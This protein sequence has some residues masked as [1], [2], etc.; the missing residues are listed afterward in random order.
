MLKK[1][2]KKLLLK[3][4]M[5][6]LVATFVIWG[7]GSAVT[8]KKGSAGSIFGRKIS[9]QEYNR[10]YHAILTRAQLIYGDNLSKFEKFLNLGQQ[11][12]DRLI[13][14]HEAR[15]KFRRPSDKEA[16]ERIANMQVFQRNGVFN[17]KLYTYII[18]DIFHSTPHDFEESVKDDLILE[19]LTDSITG[20]VEALDDEVLKGY[21]E[22]NELTDA[23][24]FLI[25]TD[26]YKKDISVDD[27]EIRF[28]YEGN[29]EDYKSPISANVNYIKIGF[30]AEEKEDARFTAEELLRYTRQHDSLKAT[31]GEYQVELKE[32]GP[33]SMDSTIPEIGLSYPFKA[34][35]FGLKKDEISDIV[36][37]PEAFYIMH[38][39]SKRLPEI[40][41]FE[42]AKGQIRDALITEK[43]E[44]KAVVAASEL[45][46]LIQKEGTTRPLEDIA[47]ELKKTLHLA[48]DVTR[49]GYI[50]DVGISESFTDALFSLGLD[51]ISEPVEI[52]TGLAII[53]RDSIRPIDEEKFE[54]EKEEFRKELLDRKRSEQFSEWFATVKD[55]AN[56]KDGISTLSQ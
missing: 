52:P 20:E 28:Y 24:F 47:G 19:K 45:H 11:A 31:A 32:T 51:D 36:E 46:L 25:R 41:P 56:L 29:K 37:T 7:A 13:L 30:A 5:W 40:L 27:E 17:P 53:R 9:L 43:A 1:L 6:S 34:A 3:I 18:K 38:L 48:K 14:L 16:A 21:K 49:K 35:A 44:E 2:Q 54:E 50:K 22:K 55:A 33:F 15:R 10:S 39:L 23:S 12:W 8:S 26:D 4:I 42:E